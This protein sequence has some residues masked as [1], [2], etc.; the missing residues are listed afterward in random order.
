MLLINT[1]YE[2]NFN[3]VYLEKQQI[4]LA[5]NAKFVPGEHNH[6]SGGTT[7]NPIK[8]FSRYKRFSKIHL[9]RMSGETADLTG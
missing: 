1:V 5:E 6:G 4:C 9:V 3:S 2:K 7:G 8:R